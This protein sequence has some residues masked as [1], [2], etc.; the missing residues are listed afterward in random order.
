MQAAEIRQLNDAELVTKF[1]ELKEELFNLRFQNAT[2]SLEKHNTIPQVK[3][4]IAR[5]QTI[6]TERALSEDGPK[7]ES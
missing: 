3:K 1:L 4:D 6:M 2:G 7:G 5:V